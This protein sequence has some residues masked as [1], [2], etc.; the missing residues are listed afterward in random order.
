[1]TALQHGMAVR[2]Q[3]TSLYD[4]RTGVLGP[5]SEDPEDFWDYT[6]ALTAAEPPAGATPIQRKLYEERTIGV[7]SSQVV[8]LPA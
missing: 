2:I 3:H 1:M 5:T 4:G 8:A 6:V 7:M